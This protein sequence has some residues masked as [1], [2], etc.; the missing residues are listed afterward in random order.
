MDSTADTEKER[1]ESERGEMIELDYVK[2]AIRPLAPES[3]QEDWYA[4]DR[5]QHKKEKRLLLT[6]IALHLYLQ[7]EK[8]N[9]LQYP[10]GERKQSDGNGR[11]SEG[12]LARLVLHWSRDLMRRAGSLVA[13]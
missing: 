5:V 10:L 2:V 4:A 6:A 13:S 11:I 9:A 12:K 3:H 7:K 1:K 8:E